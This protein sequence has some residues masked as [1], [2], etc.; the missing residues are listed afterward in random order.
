MCRAEHKSAQKR[1][2]KCRPLSDTMSVGT[3]CFEKTCCTNSWASCG[4][5]SVFNVGMK[6][7]ILVKRSTTTKIESWL[8]L[9]GSP[10]IKSM[11][12]ELH[13]RSG[14]GKNRRGP[15]GLCRIAF[16]RLHSGQDLTK[17]V[18][19]LSIPGQL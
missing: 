5:V 19:N 18:T 9:V 4:V 3:P 6:I 10:S 2:M 15:N 1:D 14:M 11:E 13:G 16:A 8:S 12:S 7:A 17:S